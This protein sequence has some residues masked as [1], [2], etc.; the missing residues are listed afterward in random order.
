[1]EYQ[2]QIN[3]NSR[4][5]KQFVVVCQFCTVVHYNTSFLTMHTSIDSVI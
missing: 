4:L 5:N 2:F 3:D 1:M